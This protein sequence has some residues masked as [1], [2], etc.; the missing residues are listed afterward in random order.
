[1]LVSIRWTRRR[2]ATGR[3]VSPLGICISTGVLPVPLCG[4]N[5]LVDGNALQ[6]VQAL[7]WVGPIIFWVC[8]IG[9]MI[10]YLCMP[11]P[12]YGLMNCSR[13]CTRSSKTTM[14]HMFK[15]L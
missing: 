12:I 6:L 1:P 5:P 13:T 2:S 4:D 3:S 8:I 10:L 9:L 14:L 11:Y 15:M 7:K